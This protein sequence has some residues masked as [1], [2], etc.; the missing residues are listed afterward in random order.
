MKYYDVAHCAQVTRRW[1]NFEGIAV[2]SHLAE[3]LKLMDEL[4]LHQLQ[5][6]PEGAHAKHQSSVPKLDTLDNASVV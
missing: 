6:I 4:I 1:F 5:A 3:Q 2:P